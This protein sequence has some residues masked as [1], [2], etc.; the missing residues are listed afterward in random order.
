MKS[1]LNFSAGIF[2][3]FVLSCDKQLDPLIEVEFSADNTSIMLGQSVSF[4]DATAGNPTSWE[5]EFEGGNPSTSIEQNPVVVF[6][7]LGVYDIKLKASNAS[8]FSE[9][10]ISKYINVNDSILNADFSSDLN[11][12][13]PNEVV[14]FLDLSSGNSISWEWTFEGANLS[15]STEQHPSIF[16]NEA[17][18]YS[19]ILKVSN[20]TYSDV[21]VKSGYITVLN[22]FEKGVIAHYKLNKNAEDATGNQIE[23]TIFESPASIADRNGVLDGAYNFVASRQRIEI[24]TDYELNNMVSVFSWVKLNA[25]TSP[26]SHYIFNISDSISVLLRVPDGF[27]A[28]VKGINGVY[29]ATGFNNYSYFEDNKWHHIGFTYDGVDL[30]LYVDGGLVQT[31]TGT[32]ELPRITSKGFIGNHYIAPRAPNTG[33]DDLRVYNRALE[34]SEVLELFNY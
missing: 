34:A 27:R 11:V 26:L 30:K 31:A 16:Y 18:T 29:L 4:T 8:N 32:V 14:S 24:E 3:I 28:G 12:I 2:L 10:L 33:I 25:F 15:T 6:E 23:G 5:W 13:F 22:T 9:L 17:G 19:V 1:L 7:N 21:M 20:S